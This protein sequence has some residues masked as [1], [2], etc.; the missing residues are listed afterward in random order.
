VLWEIMMKF[1]VGDARA[2]AFP[3]LKIERVGRYARYR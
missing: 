3:P 2:S 1:T